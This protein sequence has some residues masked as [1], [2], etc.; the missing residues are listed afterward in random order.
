[1]EDIS[2]R[3]LATLLIAAIVISL[4]GTVISLNRLSRIT[5]PAQ[6]ITGMAQTSGGQVN[7]TVQSS[8]SIVL[9]ANSIDFGTGWING[10]NPACV[11]ATG[12]ANLSTEGTGS[13]TNSCWINDSGIIGQ[14]PNPVFN[15]F[16]IENDGTINATVML[17]GQTNIT[18]LGN[19]APDYTRY[20]W[21]LDSTT[22]SNCHRTPAAGWYEFA[23]NSTI[24]QNLPWEDANDHLVVD[25]WVRFPANQTAGGYGDNTVLFQAFSS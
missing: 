1:M 20:A 17:S 9:T 21:K 8:L 14:A 19:R 24:C 25:V 12:G 15:D 10:S 7:L 16:I 23:S 3:T 4:G 11:G 5:T 2:N 13:N 22:L 18:T 6:Q